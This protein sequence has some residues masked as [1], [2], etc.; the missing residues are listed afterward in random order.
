M[1]AFSHRLGQERP[2]GERRAPASE[3]PASLT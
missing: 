2:F 3:R 1:S